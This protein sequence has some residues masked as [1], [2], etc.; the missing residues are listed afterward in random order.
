MIR[1]GPGRTTAVSVALTGGSTM[2]VCCTTSGH[3]VQVSHLAVVK[4]QIFR[5]SKKGNYAT[6][7]LM[8]AP[9]S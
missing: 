1:T 5:V 3:R 2:T 4:A 8:D 7:E 9:C 6:Q